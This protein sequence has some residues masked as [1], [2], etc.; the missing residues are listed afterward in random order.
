MNGSAYL[1]L[2]KPGIL[3]GNALTMLAGFCVASK[4]SFDLVLLGMTLMGTLLIMASSCVCNQWIDAAADSAMLRTQRRP[5]VTGAITDVNALV[6]ACVLLVL[7]SACLCIYANIL[8]LTMALLGFCAYVGIYS[9]AKYYTPYSTLLGCIS[10][11]MPP[12]V[13]YTAVHATLDLQVAVL[14]LALVL[15]QMPHFFAI[16]LYRKN[17]Y[18]AA[19]IPIWPLVK[20]DKSTRKQ[21]L[22]YLVGFVVMVPVFGYLEMMSFLGTACVFVSSLGWLFVALKKPPR[23]MARWAFQVFRFSLLVITVFSIAAFGS[24]VFS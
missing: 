22:L 20:G 7:G 18:A 24:S 9:V 16:G 23:E 15:W 2:T 19:K 3:G 1:T 4:G 12:V 13:G 21:M 5:L 14:F 6:F 17:E 10:G 8:A 11:A